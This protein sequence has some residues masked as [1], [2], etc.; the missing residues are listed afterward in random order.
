MWEY[1]HTDEMYTGRFDRSEKIVHSDVYL[2]QEYS[3]GLYHW[4]YIKRERK[5]GKWVYYYKDDKLSE[6]KYKYD[7]DKKALRYE[8]SKRGYDKLNSIHYRYNGKD[9]DDPTYTKLG[10]DAFSSSVNYK[11]AK[12]K[13]DKRKKKY[14]APIK[15]LNKMSEVGYNIRKKI[16][17]GIKHRGDF[18]RKYLF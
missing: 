15:A 17:K 3:D 16:N 7:T 9:I 13:S 1:K 4:K 6:A 18:F 2:G 10:R 8:N 11:L 12:K 14:N 5:N